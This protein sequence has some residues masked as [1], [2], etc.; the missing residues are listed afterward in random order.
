MEL[1]SLYRA[2]YTVPLTK[3]V[4][5]VRSA[6]RTEHAAAIVGQRLKR[7]P[8]IVAKLVRFPHMELSRMQDIGGC[9]AILPSTGTVAAVLR[10]IERQKSEVVS[11][12]DYN[13][14]PKPTGYR[15]IHVVVK[16]DGTLVEIQL[17]TPWQQ[18][19]ATLVENLDGTYGLTL[20]DESGAAEIL[21]YLRLLADAM[22]AR[23]ALGR[24]E[25]ERVRSLESART[26]AAAW[27][28]ARG[29]MP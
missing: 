29:R 15:A 27:L 19:W 9:R 11:I 12:D 18:D 28:A 25:A 4:M 26:V 8:R 5:G 17:R 3:V 20:K 22:H 6:A 14:S 10:R 2:E 13:R 21:D 7:Q 23:Y 1:L 16:R 24:L